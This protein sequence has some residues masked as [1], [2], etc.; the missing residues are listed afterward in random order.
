MKALRSALRGVMI[1]RQSHGGQ[2]TRHYLCKV[3]KSQD[4]EGKFNV[5]KGLGL[6]K[7]VVFK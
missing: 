1:G 4:W 6:W 2:Q 5:Q 3:L 7:A